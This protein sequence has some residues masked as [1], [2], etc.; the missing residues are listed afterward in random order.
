MFYFIRHGEPDYSEKNTKI[1]RG[2]GEQMCPL[3]QKG[4]EQIK[5]TAKDNRLKKAD[6][7]LSSPYTRALQTAAII[8]RESGADIQIETDLH[9]WLANK[10]YIYEC[11]ACAIN[12]LEEFDK[13][14]GCYPPGEERDWETFEQMRV[15]ALNV[16]K[17]YQHY[18]KVIITCHGRL[19]QAITGLHH[20]HHGEIFEFQL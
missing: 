12:N 5:Q 19:M 15:R 8:S 16:L 1:Y 14:N 3:T 18:D 17:K 2:F 7:I 9:E 13:N 10:N 6:V 20:P 11:E 4:C